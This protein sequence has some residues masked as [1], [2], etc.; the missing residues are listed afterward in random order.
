MI[1]LERKKIRGAKPKKKKRKKKY[2]WGILTIHGFI[3]K[4]GINFMCF[5]CLGLNVQHL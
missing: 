1:E 3:E 2:K 5:K 4:W